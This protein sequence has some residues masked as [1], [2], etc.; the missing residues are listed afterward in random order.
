LV[1]IT[2]C[3]SSFRRTFDALTGRASVPALA[4]TIP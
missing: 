2:G 1:G 4:S 3:S